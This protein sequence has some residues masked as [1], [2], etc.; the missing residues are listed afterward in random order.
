MKTE[1]TIY[2]VETFNILCEKIPLTAVKS[3]DK[4]YSI[5]PAYRDDCKSTTQQ[6]YSEMNTAS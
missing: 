4:V 1:D 5:S 2:A 3:Y 6:K